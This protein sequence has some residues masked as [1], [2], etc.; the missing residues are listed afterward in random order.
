VSLEFIWGFLDGTEFVI[1]GDSSTIEIKHSEHP[2]LPA[3]EEGTALQAYASMKRK[4]E[5]HPEL[6]PAQIIRND[7][8]QVQAVANYVQIFTRKSNSVVLLIIFLKC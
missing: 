1:V 4:A 2:Q 5:E 3:P 6:S 8:P 7:L